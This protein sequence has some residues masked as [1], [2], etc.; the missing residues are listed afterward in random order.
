MRISV[1]SKEYITIPVTADEVVTD[2][3]V[4]FSFTAPGVQPT[5]WTSGDWTPDGRARVLVGPSVLP[6]TVGLLDVWIK[7]TD[8][9]EVPVRKVG[10][11]SVY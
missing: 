7:V 4:A 8:S 1:L 9:P 5:V 3:P 6:L 10:Q 11:I 2:D